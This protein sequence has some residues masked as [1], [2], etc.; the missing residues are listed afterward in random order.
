VHHLP[1]GTET[2]KVVHVDY[3]PLQIAN[4]EVVNGET[5]EAPAITLTPGGRVEGIVYHDDGSIAA[6]APVY[7]RDRFG[8][9]GD[10]KAG[11]IAM[12]S[13]DDAGRF[14]VDH[15][16]EQ[17]LYVDLGDNRWGH[18]GVLRR[19]VRP[20]EG[21][22][23]TLDFGGATTVTGRLVAG[24]VVKA[25]AKLALS[26]GDRYFGAFMAQ[27][28]TDADGRF[29]LRGIPSGRYVLY[30]D[31]P[32]DRIQLRE[33]NIASESIDLGDVSD[34]RGRVTL[35]IEADDP[36]EVAAIEM[37]E[38]TPDARATGWS[39]GIARFQ[40]EG[41]R[42]TCDDVPSGKHYVSAI[43]KNYRFGGRVSI[44]RT[45]GEGEMSLSL[46][47][48]KRSATLHYTP[49][50]QP[51]EF[52]AQLEDADGAQWAIVGG[53]KP[54]DVTLPPGTFR[55]VDSRSA[56]DLP[57]PPITIR[58]GETIAFTPP[59]ESPARRV[60]VDI[61]LWTGDGAH[62][63]DASATLV[64]ASGEAMTPRVTRGR[65]HL[66]FA[67]EPGRYTLKIDKPGGAPFEQS[68][69]V[70]ATEVRAA[71]HVVNVVVR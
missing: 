25:N 31:G 56:A 54:L 50:T 67:L 46:H 14:V 4:I 62:L 35:T 48:P 44:D 13:T 65:E 59:I 7:F 60:P 32:T 37:V 64:D 26:S 43:L 63:T 12:T 1:A 11:T 6:G 24:A 3:A 68:I 28:T 47:L 30:V 69:D 9:N 21:K 27:C 16:P 49:A 58:E 41:G 36:N 17:T 57:L 66:S 10:E 42:W 55:F 33:V 51:S 53:D 38:L 8:Y 20:Q 39:P 45:I 15:L 71:S 23:A 70:A 61:W 5:R 22:T 18:P 29:T 52:W 19:V 2:L 34:E 40:R